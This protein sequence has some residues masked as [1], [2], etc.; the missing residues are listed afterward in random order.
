VRG[1]LRLG[2]V[3]QEPANGEEL[4]AVVA[5]VIAL[6]EAAQPPVAVP[7]VAGA[8]HAVEAGDRAARLL[9]ERRPVGTDRI[10]RLEQEPARTRTQHGRRAQATELAQGVEAVRLDRD[11][12]RCLER[13]RHGLQHQP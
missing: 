11:E 12:I 10:E 13:W 9:P 2:Q 3:A 6:G 1:H 4:V 7:A 8:G 5:P